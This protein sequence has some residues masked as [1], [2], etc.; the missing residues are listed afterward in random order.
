ML[1]QLLIGIIN[2][3]VGGTSHAAQV[4]LRESL[5]IYIHLHLP[6]IYRI[7]VSDHLTCNLYILQG[8]ALN[9]GNPYRLALVILNGTQ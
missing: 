5:H 8:L 1:L 4:W 9:L 2:R 3:L 6:R 7:R